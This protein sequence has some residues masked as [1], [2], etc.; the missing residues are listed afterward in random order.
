[1][2]GK[3]VILMLNLPSYDFQTNRSRYDYEFLSL[4]P[5]G[6]IRKVARFDSLGT[7]IYNFGFGDLDEETG[8]ISDL[9]TSNNGDRDVVLATVA[10]IIYDFTN[11]FPEAAILIKGSDAAR[12]R[13]Y[14]LGINK[15]WEQ[16]EPVF[17]IQAY[18]DGKWYPFEKGK[19]YEAFLGRRKGGFL[20]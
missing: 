12:T 20:F 7:N 18:R 3:F 10:N 14:Q 13:L 2:I 5:R 15:Y 19:N 16:I 9:I 6:V 8:E 1:M 17:D 4:G 11:H